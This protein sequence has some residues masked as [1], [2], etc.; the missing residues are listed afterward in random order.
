LEI[1]IALAPQAQSRDKKDYGTGLVVNI[2]APEAEVV[3]AVEDVVQDGII[4]GSKEYNKDEYIS[5]AA[6]ASDS[7]LFPAWTAGGKVFYKVRLHALDPRNF[8]DSGD[9]GTLAVR[10]VVMGQS[11]QTTVLRIDAVFVEEF[12]RTAHASNGSVESGEYKDVHDRIEAIE[13]T[14]RQTGDL[15][16]EKEEATQKPI[17]ATVSEQTPATAAQSTEENP[18]AQTAGTIRPAENLEQ[19]LQQL[20]RQVE[21]LVKAP[22]APLK[23]APFHTATNLQSLPAGT[24]VLIV[25]ST[26]YWYGVETHDGQHG[27]MLRDELEELP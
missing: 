7:R 2:P 27:W 25:L 4:R 14:K 26:T 5:G 21:R 15:E 19:R 20:R 1:L 8:K 17:A 12:R 6:A 22:G 16:K 13:L 10:Y 24:E 3:Q 23:S 11:D 9:M 18:P